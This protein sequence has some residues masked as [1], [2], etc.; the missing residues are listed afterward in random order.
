MC[1]NFV[2]S[3]GTDRIQA[4]L[5]NISEVWAL[6]SVIKLRQLNNSLNNMSDF[7]STNW[8]NIVQFA[9]SQLTVSTV[10][11]DNVLRDHWPGY[12]VH[13]RVVPTVSKVVLTLTRVVP[14]ALVCWLRFATVDGFGRPGKSAAAAAVTLT[15]QGEM[16]TSKTK[17]NLRVYVWE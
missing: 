13:S 17:K 10:H 3:L 5:H 15:T 6:T 7:S 14:C 11:I 4:P 8:Q 12:T 9:S 16:C 2:E 1:V